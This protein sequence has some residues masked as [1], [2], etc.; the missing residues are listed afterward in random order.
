MKKS[1]SRVTDTLE[2]IAQP[3]LR[4]A[5]AERVDGRTARWTE[6]R[7]A[8]RAQLVD[9]AIAAVNRFG[10][11]VGMDQIAQTART[12]KPVIYR[13][14]ADKNELYRAVG[15]R[16]VAQI[17]DA[18]RG[19]AP[20]GDPRQL[21]RASID[22]YLELLEEHP[23]LFRFVTQNRLPIDARSGEPTAAEF[24]RPVVE[25][26]T[27]ALGEQLRSI[28]LDPAGARPWG[29][30]AVGFIRAAS[31]WWLDNPDCMTRLQLRE[32]LAALLWGGGAGVFQFAG[33]EVDAR[34]GPGVFATLPR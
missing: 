30:A 12:S 1:V 28:G 17:V 9:A 6:H 19:V 11:D 8:R 2:A 27:T 15:A 4:A 33:R 31:L 32:Y 26:L 18:L 3:I 13:Y 22:A 23:R 5:H 7:I 25:V 16:V 20:D 10:S 14:F 34:P 29:E 24:S 21:L